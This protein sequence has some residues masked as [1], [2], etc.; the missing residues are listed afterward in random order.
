[1][2]GEEAFKEFLKQSHFSREQY[3]EYV[4]KTSAASSALLA[5]MAKKTIPTPADVAEYYRTHSKML[6]SPERLSG[7]QIFFDTRAT[8]LRDQIKS[9][10]H[11]NDGPELDR[12]VTDEIAHRQ[13]L[14]EEVRGK[15]TESGADFAALARKYSDDATTR[16]KGGRFLKPSWDFML[17][18]F[19]TESRRRRK[20]SKKRLRRFNAGSRKAKRPKA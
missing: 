9:S 5:D 6:R 18:R 1:M 10:R 12:A 2:S 20:H 19:S 8:F 4:L 14:A 17:S 16:D 15:A 3:R 11:L 7:A 13:K